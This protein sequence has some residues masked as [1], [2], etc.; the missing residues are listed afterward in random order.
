MS[1]IHV[2]PLVFIFLTN[3]SICLSFDFTISS[4]LLNFRTSIYTWSLRMSMHLSLWSS[5]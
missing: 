3:S 1:S 2:K 5:N 4:N